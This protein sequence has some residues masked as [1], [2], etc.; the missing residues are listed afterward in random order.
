ML[1][2]RRFMYPSGVERV[3]FQA[4][5]VPV[6]SRTRWFPGGLRTRQEQNVLVSGLSRVVDVG[7]SVVPHGTHAAACHWLVGLTGERVGKM[8]VVGDSKI[9]PVKQNMSY[10]TYGI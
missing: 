8:L 3:G 1:V 7:K 4:V 2:S 10:I 9:Q 6:R 5:Y